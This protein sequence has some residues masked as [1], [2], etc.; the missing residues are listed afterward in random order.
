MANQLAAFQAAFP[1]VVFRQKDL[2]DGFIAI[3]ATHISGE[4]LCIPMQVDNPAEAGIDVF[5]E[6]WAAG[7]NAID[8]P[9]LYRPDAE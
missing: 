5:R 8:H 7:P 9:A 1:D 2:P 3:C 4:P 6:L